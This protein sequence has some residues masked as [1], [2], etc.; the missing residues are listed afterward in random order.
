VVRAPG[1]G[2]INSARLRYAAAG[3]NA[4]QPPAGTLVLSA[5]RWFTL[6]S[7]CSASCPSAISSIVACIGSAKHVAY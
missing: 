4:M 3:V 1:G 5:G 2:D 7:S 6:A